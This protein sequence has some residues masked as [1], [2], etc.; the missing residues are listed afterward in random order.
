M[1]S[2]LLLLLFPLAVFAQRPDEEQLRQRNAKLE[3]IL[4]TQD[5]RTLHDGTLVS[6]LSDTDPVV[7][8]RA[9]F[10]FGS[11]QD[12]SVMTTLVANLTDGPP[13]LQTT[14]AWAIGQTAPALHL[15]TRQLLEHDL[16]WTRLDQSKA[17]ERLIEEIGKF[18]TEQGL[19]DL[20]QRFGAANEHA[21]AMMMSIARFGIRGITSADAV[22]YLLRFIQ[23]AESAHWQAVYA[24]Q[25]IGDHEETR[26]QI[27]W[28]VPLRL[29]RDP[30]VRM[31]AATLMGKLR[32]AQRSVGPLM[33]LA[34]RD[35]DWRVRVNALKALGN[36]SL[37]DDPG[38]AEAF[39]RSF[40][41]DN[42]HVAVTALAAFGST[43]AKEYAPG[44]AAAFAELRKIAVN[45][46]QGFLWQYQAEAALSLARLIGPKALVSVRPVSSQGVPLQ[47][48]LIAAA[49]ATGG[50]EAAVLL[51][52]YLEDENP[53]LARA[54]L[55]GLQE[56]SQKLP[57]DS[58]VVAKTYRAAVAA[59]GRADVA[60]VT[61]AAGVLGD[62]LFRRREAVGPLLDALS[63]SRIPDDIEAMQEIMATLGKIGDDRA[64]KVLEAQLS[65]RNQSVA[66][67]AAG[68]LKA[69]TGTSYLRQID[70]EYEPPYVDFDFEYLR[71]L[72]ETVKVAL[73][74]IRG[75]VTMELYKNVAPFTVMSFLKLATQRGF[76]RGLSF[77]RVVPN[78]VV[79]GGDPRGDGWGGAGYAIRSE[80]SPLRYETGTVGVASAGKDT[81]GS[82]FFIT[83]SPQPHLEGRYTIFGKVTRGMDVVDKIM[84]DDHIFDIQ[85]V[86]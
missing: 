51:G 61:T 18:G 3:T 6:L 64:V 47:A 84:V 48:R 27:E 38:L 40:L 62:S 24:L 41:A 17:Q 82:Q 12:T 85:I 2:L 25:R 46:G 8:E 29:H 86:R 79:Q 7:R 9:T 80:F 58:V 54:A 16:I 71:A 67:A 1:K 83:Q 53:V 60:M 55:E 32:D 35:P 43:G 59:L 42:P 39:R 21:T 34:E 73:S 75:D 52:Q 50:A 65:V 81:E 63:R 49:G 44:A 4:R 20:L 70:R 11:I 37:S 15:K 76:Y 36:F 45:D 78:F 69:I 30:L 68:A 31:N 74:T 57:S 56:L 13:L 19:A 10:A 23:P 28:I 22:R 66:L 26:S 5:L 72:P 33:T 77:H 14:A